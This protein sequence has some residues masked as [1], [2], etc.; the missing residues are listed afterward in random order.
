M[1]RSK[2]YRNVL[3]CQWMLSMTV[4][5]LCSLA[6]LPSDDLAR[7]NEGRGPTEAG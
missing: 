3:V 4:L 5:S 1:K 6:H 7:A 2:G